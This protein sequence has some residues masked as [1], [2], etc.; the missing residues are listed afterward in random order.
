MLQTLLDALAEVHN[1]DL[2]PGQANAMAALAGAIVKVY[3]SGQLEERLEA[4]EQAA[5]EE[6]E[7]SSEAR[8]VH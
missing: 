3:S 4:L 8:R 7:F 1:G 5:R 6:A 2:E